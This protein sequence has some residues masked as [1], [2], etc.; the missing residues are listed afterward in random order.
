MSVEKRQEIMEK[1]PFGARVRAFMS[2]D[3]EELWGLVKEH[4]VEYPKFSL[5]VGMKILEMRG[6]DVLLKF[7]ERNDLKDEGLARRLSEEARDKKEKG[8]S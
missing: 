3:V 7:L 4:E 2:D 8:G 6:P 5:Y 1:V